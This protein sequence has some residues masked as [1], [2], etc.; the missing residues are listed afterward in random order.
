[1]STLLDRMKGIM[2]NENIKPRQL[3]AELGISNSSFT[4]WGKGKGNPSVA[5]LTKFATRFHVSLD[6][7]VFGEE[8]T[9]NSLDSSSKKDLELINK[10]HSLTPEYQS[11]L[12]GYIDGMLAAMNS[13]SEAKQ[14]VAE[15]EEV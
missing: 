2:E 3:T 9:L 14:V 4:D 15:P 7:L 1:M 10:F 12:I 13:S 8:P 6:Y 5:V 11:Q